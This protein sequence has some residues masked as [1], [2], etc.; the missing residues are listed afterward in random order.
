MLQLERDTKDTVLLLL[1]RQLKPDRKLYI[2]EY[3]KDYYV[4]NKRIN[5][6]V[7]DVDRGTICKLSEKENKL[8]STFVKEIVICRLKEE[9]YLQEEIKSGLSEFVRNIRGIA[10]N[11]N[12]IARNTN[13]TA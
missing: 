4:R 5:L 8:P 3:Q 9:Y 12:Q 11:V 13:I 6:T 1:L 7:N 2:K 10:N